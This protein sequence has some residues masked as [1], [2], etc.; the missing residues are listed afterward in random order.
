MLKLTSRDIGII[1]HWADKSQDSPF[2]QE[3]ALLQRIRKSALNRDM[4]FS[5]KE[6]KI[7]LHWADQETRGH[8]GTEQ[9]LLE[10]EHLLLQK[11]ES[12]ME[13]DY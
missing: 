11:I 10:Q 13:D 5:R 2:P 1:R 8:F 3:K 9:Y 12:F 4:L 7:I 6:L